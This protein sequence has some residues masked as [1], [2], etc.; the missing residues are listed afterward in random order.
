MHPAREATG[1]TD[2]RARRGWRAALGTIGCA[3]VI[4]SCAF[5]WVPRLALGDLLDPTAVSVLFLAEGSGPPI[6]SA[7]MLAGLGGLAADLFASRTAIRRLLGVIALVAWL[8]WL[9][10][11]VYVIG[12]AE[13]GAGIFPLA[14]LR[15]GFYLALV[16]AMLMM[17][18]RRSDLLPVSIHRLGV[19]PVAGVAMVLYSSVVAW[20]ELPNDILLPVDAAVHAQDISVPF[21]MFRATLPLPTMA[22][23]LVVLGLAVLVA[24]RTPGPWTNA[25]H[26][27]LGAVVLALVGATLWY[28]HQNAEA[29]TGG[30]S[31]LFGMI[32]L[33]PYLA[34][35]GGLGLAIPMSRK[36]RQLEEG[37][38][39]VPA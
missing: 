17:I 32:R 35:L 33:G 34:I 15:A 10:N 5:A 25:L 20:F 24:L 21:M 9:L 37:A 1:A 38:P 12:F 26:R 30:Q 14:P 2:D 7:L 31:G 22:Q 4:L 13:G 8:R 23:V 19:V 11:F 6:V 27:L 28:T 18:G 29:L 16:G 39:A 36:P 3:L